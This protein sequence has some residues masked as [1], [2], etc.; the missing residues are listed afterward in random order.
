MQ[1]PKERVKKNWLFL[2]FDLSS[3]LKIEFIDK[4]REVASDA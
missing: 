3:G 2:F 4:D 1:K